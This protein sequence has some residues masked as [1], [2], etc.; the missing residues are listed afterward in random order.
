MFEVLTD[1]NVEL[2]ASKM[3][4]NLQCTSIEEFEDDM[5]RIKYLKRLF[6]RYLLYDELKERLILNHVIVF[7][8]VFTPEAATRILFL[9]I[10]DKFYS[11]LKTFLVYLNYMPDVVRGIEGKNII[12]SEIPIESCIANELRNI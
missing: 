11:I 3:Y 8:N 5:K 12:S 6:N 4:H 2:Y 10:D 1:K 9:K 7:Y